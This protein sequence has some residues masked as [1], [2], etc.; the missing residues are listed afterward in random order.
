MFSANFCG[1]QYFELNWAYNNI[2]TK[3]TIRQL[4]T[5]GAIT[6]LQCT[7][8]FLQDYNYEKIWEIR[9]LI[10]EISFMKGEYNHSACMSEPQSQ[11]RNKDVIQLKDKEWI[12]DFLPSTKHVIDTTGSN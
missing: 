8:E 12:I 11:K 7:C 4:S 9:S 2:L 3:V 5:Y 6:H 10:K 1:G